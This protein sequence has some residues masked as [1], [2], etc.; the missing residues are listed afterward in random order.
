MDLK[1]LLLAGALWT[2]LLSPTA[3]AYTMDVSI[4]VETP[5]YQVG[6]F[7]ITLFATMMGI[8]FILTVLKLYLGF[9]SSSDF[10][11]KTF[12][13]VVFGFLITSVIGI[14]LTLA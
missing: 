11:N 7:S 8:G 2:V 4:T 3:L 13:V 1:K 10:I 6:L 12:I 14:L 9:D 5:L